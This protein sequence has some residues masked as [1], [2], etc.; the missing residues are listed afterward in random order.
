M[1]IPLIKGR[2]FTGLDREEM[3]G[4]V[5]I[6][7]TFA[8]R[9]F[10]NE[11]CLGKRVRFRKW[12][13]IVGVV[14]D[15]RGYSLQR[16][17][18]P[19][20]YRSYLQDGSSHMRLLVRT[21]GDPIKWA[22]AVR[23]QIASIDKD[24]PPHDL[25]TFEQR[26]A[27]YL[28]PQRVTMLLLGAFAAL[29]LVLASVGIYGV[30]SYSVTQRTHE[31]G[32]RGALGALESDIMRSVLGQGIALIIAGILVG[33]AETLRL[34]RFIRSLLY[35]VE[36][37]DPVTFAGISLLLLLVAVAVCYLPARRATRVDPMV[38]LRH[39]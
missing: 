24:Q 34:T 38:A 28:Q 31:I 15:V 35:G 26:L 9:F 27:E 4:V 22:A 7:E 20:M 37:T 8:R 32:V 2:Y 14:G 21:V 16:E 5:I 30:I 29:A 3:P 6:N 33:L 17:T 13:T 36:E 18:K 25:M 23:S 19:T 11:D 39:E 1:G 12:M 10:P